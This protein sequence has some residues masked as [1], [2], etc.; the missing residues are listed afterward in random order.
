M[1]SIVILAAMVALALAGPAAGEPDGKAVAGSGD[2]AS[3]ATLQDFLTQNVCVDRGGQVLRGVSPVDDDSR[4][5]SQRDLMPGERLPYHKHDHPS[6]DQRGTA[7]TGYQR[8]DSVPVDTAQFGVVIEQSFDFGAGQGRRFGVFDEAGGDGGDIMILSA[9]DASIAATQDGG[10]GFQ[11][12]TGPACRGAVTPDGLRDSW[13]TAAI[14]GE[15]PLAGNAIAHL[16]DLAI[17]RQNLTA[18]PPECPSRLD[19][20]YTTWRVVPFRYRSAPGQ[21]HGFS[22]P[23]LISEH[24]AGADP[25]RAPHAE[26]FYYTRALGSTRWERWERRPSPGSASAADFDRRAETFAASQRCGPA[27]PPF[28]D[29]ALVVVDCR[30]WTL[31]VASDHGDGDPPGFFIDFLKKQGDE[32]QLF[33][34]FKH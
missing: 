11:L 15:H 31:I 20:A 29:A 10:A 14:D 21:G 17:A 25:A 1:K 16:K 28:D 12:F 4:C 32:P 23:T 19:E 33:T 34:N 3:A 6:P 27:P 7:P 13:L 18:A 26:R 22:L 9:H 8:H 24:F 30:E 2:T 5:V